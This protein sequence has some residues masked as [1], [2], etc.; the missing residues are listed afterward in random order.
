MKLLDALRLWYYN[1]PLRTYV[2]EPSRPIIARPIIDAYP[3]NRPLV[4]KDLYNIGWNDGYK[5]GSQRGQQK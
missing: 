1:V 5:V 4:E 3:R 2:I